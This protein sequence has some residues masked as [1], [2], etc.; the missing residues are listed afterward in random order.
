MTSPAPGS[1]R[2]PRTF[3]CGHC[4]HTGPVN[5]TDR[6]LHHGCP[7]SMP[8]RESREPVAVSH[9]CCEHCTHTGP[10][11]HF[12]DPCLHAGCPASLK[13]IDTTAVT[14]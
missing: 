8:D 10:N 6:C 9:P 14:P 12:L 11:A 4:T 13:G 1:S 5:H 3:C 2:E 7:A